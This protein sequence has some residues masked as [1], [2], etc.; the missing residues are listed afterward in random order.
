VTVCP[1]CSSTAVRPVVRIDDVPVLCNVLHPDVDAARTAPRG[2]LD[3]RA[4]DGCAHLFNAAFDPGRVPYAADYENSLHFSPRFQEWAVKLA[5]DLVRRHGLADGGEVVEVACG[6]GDFL[7]LLR[8][9]GARRGIG[10]DPSWEPERAGAPADDRVEIR[11]ELFDAE[12]AYD[13]DAALLCCRHALEHVDD[14][15]GFLAAMHRAL[16][17]SPR[18]PLYLE[19]P[20]GLWTL[21]DLGV[22]DLIY[23]HPHYFSPRS[24]TRAVAGG[25][26]A[27]IEVAE[28]FGGQFL[29]CHARRNPNAFADDAPA[30]AADGEDPAPADFTA[31]TEGFAD[32]WTGLRDRWRGR[33]AALAADGRRAAVWGAGSK[34]VTFANSVDESGCID[35][36]VDINPH[37]QGRF[38]PG[39]GHAVTGPEDLAGRGVDLV[40]VMN[41]RYRD[42]IAAQLSELGIAADVDV[43]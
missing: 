27:D 30:S 12:T 17:R 2:D 9:A 7:G 40:V 18:A 41:P 39:T 13:L 4:C 21:R 8:E 23:E 29:A 43:V 1:V 31:M 19:V 26:F 24:L 28:D 20:N 35:A 33:L 16:A 15:P 37:K 36:L 6:K 22:W 42:E 38:V 3:L 5:A 14:P 32:A 10:F 11:A 34:G 25:G